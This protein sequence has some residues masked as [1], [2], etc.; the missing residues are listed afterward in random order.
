MWAIC[1][2]ESGVDGGRGAESGGLEA[3]VMDLLT[4]G[5]AGAREFVVRM[6]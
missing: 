5:V 4:S 3:A 6:L 2:T 1:G